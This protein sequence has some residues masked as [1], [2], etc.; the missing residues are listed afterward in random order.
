MTIFP[1]CMYVHC[2]HAWCPKRPEEVPDLLELEL[3][4]TVEVQV[5][6]ECDDL[7]NSVTA[8]LPGL[9][10]KNNTSRRKDWPP[11]ST[12]SQ[13]AP[14]P[15]DSGLVSS[16][17]L[18]CHTDDHSLHSVLYGICHNLGFV[19]Y[20][21]FTQPKN[22]PW[23]TRTQEQWHLCHPGVHILVTLLDKI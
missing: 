16:M 1:A 3:T 9:C 23:T 19:C 11:A 5:N 22:L 4:P 18:W 17:P 15:T 6:R 2:L 10:I 14:A 12:P 8:I 13:P 21:S 7:T 20:G